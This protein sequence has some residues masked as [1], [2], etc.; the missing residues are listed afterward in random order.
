MPSAIRTGAPELNTS[1]VRAAAIF[2][3]LNVKNYKLWH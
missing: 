3:L 2:F 1:Q